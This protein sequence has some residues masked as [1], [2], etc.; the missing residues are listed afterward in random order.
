MTDILILLTGF[1]LSALAIIISVLTDRIDIASELTAGCPFWIQIAGAVIITPLL[2]ALIY[3]L[4]RKNPSFD[5]LNQM[6]RYLV[7]ELNPSFKQVI[8]LSLAAGIGE[9]L[10]FRGVVQALIG[11]VPTSIIFAGLHTG[12]RFDKKALR[13]YFAMVFIMSLLLGL[14]FRHVGLVAAM[15][16]HALWDFSMILLVKNDLSKS[17][18]NPE[19]IV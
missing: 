11:I 1:G 9:E 17:R 8:A 10:L 6:T 7:I 3:F 4:T 5:D 14:V 19:I 18:T 16:T 2:V 15:T 12:F 13:M